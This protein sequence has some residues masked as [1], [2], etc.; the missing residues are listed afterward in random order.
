[1]VNLVDNAVEVARIIMGI[2]KPRVAVLSANEKQIPSLPSTWMGKRLAE[3]EWPHACVCGPLS[4]DL[5]TDPESVEVKGMP[6]ILNAEQVA[7]RAD[8]LVCPGIDAANILYKTFTAM[9]K[10]G[11]ASMAG[12]TVGFPVPYII[13]SRADTLETRLLS[14]A[15]C[16]IY[17]QRTATHRVT[18]NGAVKTGTPIRRDTGRPSK[19]F[20]ILV[21]NPGSTSLKLALYENERALHEE[22]I[23]FAAP[24]P[25]SR[26]AMHE[27]A[28]AMAKQVLRACEAWDTEVHAL[29][30]RGGFVPR[31]AGKLSSGTYGI[32]EVVNG[33]LRIDD[34][35]VEGIIEHAEHRHASN[36]GIPVAAL[37]AEHFRVPA[38]TVDPVIVDEFSPEGGISGYAPVERRSIAH[39]LSVHAAARRAAA[40]TGRP[41]EDAS[42]VVAHL[43]GGITVAAVRGGRVVDSNIALLGDGPFTPQ[44]AGTLPLAGIIDLCYSGKFARDELEQELSRRGGVYSYLGESDM[45]KIE[46]RIA[47]GDGEARLVIDAMVYRVACAIGAMHAALECDAEAIILTG[48]LMKSGLIRGALRKRVTRMAPVIVYQGSLEMEALAAGA[49]RVLSGKAEALRFPES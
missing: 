32:A 6:D 23:G 39:S 16:S 10:Y 35:L 24:A 37:L 3:K 5:A 33:T 46:E 19:A 31:T 30:A 14:I 8:V 15:L 12:I 20:R 36:F 40:Q 1:M 34:H 41:L 7:G 11:Q 21:V 4:F 49:C 25:D 47:G 44:R 22:E 27:Q 17:A 18:R 29:A 45:K 48:G 42:L 2:E 13:L 26:E 28:E 9:T 38:Y 43:G